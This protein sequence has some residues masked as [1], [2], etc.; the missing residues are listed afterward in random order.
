MVDKRLN[1]SV[2]FTCMHFQSLQTFTG[3]MANVT[4]KCFPSIFM[5]VTNM[6]K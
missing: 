6:N 4:E 5:N 2:E 3:F 1:S